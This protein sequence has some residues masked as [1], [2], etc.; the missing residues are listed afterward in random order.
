MQNNLNYAGDKIIWN[1]ELQDQLSI[2]FEKRPIFQEISENVHSNE[3]T[4]NQCI[5]ELSEVIYS[6]SFD[7][8]EKNILT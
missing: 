6:V 3:Y 4:V 2:T 7:L 1:H 8:C 5:T